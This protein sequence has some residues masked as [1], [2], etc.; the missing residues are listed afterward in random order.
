M[1][2]RKKLVTLG[3][4]KNN[5]S[6]DGF[7]EVFRKSAARSFKGEVNVS[8]RAFVLSA[9]LMDQ[10]GREPWLQPSNPPPEIVAAAAAFV[11]SQRDAFDLALAFDGTMKEPRRALEDIFSPLT[12]TADFVVVYDKAPNSC[13]Q[14][15]NFMS[16]R[17]V[18]AGFVRMPMNRTRVAVKDRS[19]T[20]SA[21]GETSTTYTSYSGIQGIP[22]TTLAMI[23]PEDKAKIFADAPGPLPK[24]WA[25][26][27]SSGVP[28]FWLE[29]KS[30]AFWG[31]MC[32][33]LNIK[34]IVDLSPGSGILAQC[35]MSRGIQYFGLCSSGAH[36][37]W[38]VKCYRPSCP[39]VY[40]G[41]RHLPLHGG[42]RHAHQGVVRRLPR[43][44]REHQGGRR[45]SAGIR[46]GGYVVDVSEFR[47]G[48]EWA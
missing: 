16:Q 31:Q 6:E 21:S 12:A 45:G 19:E 33:D 9:D 23:S 14:R 47:C 17:N 25:E 40:C 46:S 3:L 18:E 37:Q 28:L 26:S 30:L 1:A 2:Q 10:S 34:C 43:V 48:R 24:R 15:K 32:D 5:K 4:V 27:R 29:T 8:H 20:G 35:C 44:L 41:D 42:P 36:L 11:T 22:R 38:F 13:F 7:R 39:Q